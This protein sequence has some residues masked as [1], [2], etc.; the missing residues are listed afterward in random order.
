M[1]TRVDN[2]APSRKQPSLFFKTWL[3]HAIKYAVTANVR[4][5]LSSSGKCGY[6]ACDGTDKNMPTAGKKNKVEEVQESRN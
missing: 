4:L 1:T 6:S 2:S 5:R 3:F